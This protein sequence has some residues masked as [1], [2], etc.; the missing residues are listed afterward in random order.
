[1]KI[2]F[3]ILSS[4]FLAFVLQGC[5]GGLIIAAGTAAYISSDERSVTEQF[6]DGK[7]SSD[8]LDTINQLNIA[9]DDLRINLITNSGYLL[10]LGQV[11]DAQ[12]KDN[13]SKSLAKIDGIKEVYNQLRIQRPI[14]FSQQSKDSWITTKVK[15]QFTSDER[16]NPLKIKVITENSEV[17]LIAK[18]DSKMAKY[19]TNIARNVDG[20]KKVNRVFQLSD[21]K[22][23]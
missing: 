7:I 6:D 17:F 22:K 9:R 14:D 3:K 21:E 10:V 15:S 18:I 11:N 4:V 23:D 12:T 16:V 1:M 2:Y 8:A 19:A 20:V 5:A 13:I